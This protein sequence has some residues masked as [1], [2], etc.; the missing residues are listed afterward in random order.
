MIP[1][2]ITPEEANGLSKALQLGAEYLRAESEGN[3]KART[4]LMNRFML[5][6]LDGEFGEAMKQ[7][8]VDCAIQRLRDYLV[9]QINGVT[10]EPVA[11]AS[12][13]CG[14]VHPDNGGA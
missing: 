7:K 8:A 1:E 14:E 9:A 10:D 13:A 11:N 5:R 2:N 4:A 12:A 6:S 3:G